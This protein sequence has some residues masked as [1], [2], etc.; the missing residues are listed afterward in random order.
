MNRPLKSYNIYITLG[1][2]ILF[3]TDIVEKKVD[4][5]RLLKELNCKSA[6][7]RQIREFILVEDFSSAAILLRRHRA[8]LLEELHESQSRVDCLDFIL[9]QMNRLQSNKV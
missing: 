8:A 7:V 9:Y 6:D 5:I 1:K 2:E 3:M 4:L